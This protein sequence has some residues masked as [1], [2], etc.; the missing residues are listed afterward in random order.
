MLWTDWYF[1]LRRLSSLQRV[2]IRQ[3]VLL[4]RQHRKDSRLLLQLQ[5]Q[6]QARLLLQTRLPR[7]RHRQQVST[8]TFS[9][10][11]GE[12]SWEFIVKSW[13]HNHYYQVLPFTFIDFYFQLRSMTT[14]VIKQWNIM[15]IMSFRTMTLTQIWVQTGLSNQVNMKNLSHKLSLLRNKTIKKDCTDR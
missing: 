15:H 12:T 10:I 4:P 13:H 1:L 5:S 9:G 7:R 8:R 14:K 2:L 11:E 3:C 6:L